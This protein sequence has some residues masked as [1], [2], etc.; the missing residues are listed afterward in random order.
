METTRDTLVLSFL[1]DTGRARS[2]SIPEPMSGLGAA[3]VT[4]AALDI[5]DADI[6]DPNA[7]AGG[8]LASLRGAVHQRVV[9]RALF[10]DPPGLPPGG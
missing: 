8:R 4:M 10:G 2:M 9:A 5:V 7:G 3:A 1:T 6:F